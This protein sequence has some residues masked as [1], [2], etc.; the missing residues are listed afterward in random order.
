MPV[1]LAAATKES[2]WE[3][4]QQLAGREFKGEEDFCGWLGRKHAKLSGV[5]ARAWGKA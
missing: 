1:A 3:Q 2:L 5:Q 4:V